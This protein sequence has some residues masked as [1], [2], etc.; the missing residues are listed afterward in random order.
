MNDPISEGEKRD[1]FSMMGIK[2]DR[3]DSF[4]HLGHVIRPVEECVDVLRHMSGKTKLTDPEEETVCR[5]ALLLGG[6]CARL[7]DDIRQGRVKPYAPVVDPFSAIKE[8]EG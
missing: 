7:V 3:I 2:A 1:I 6:V 8:E 4:Q 5:A